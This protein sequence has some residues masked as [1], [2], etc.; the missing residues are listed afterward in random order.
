MNL[1]KIGQFPE[2][3]KQKT[4]SNLPFI[5]KVPTV[6][7]LLHYS[8]SHLSPFPSENQYKSYPKNTRII[9][10]GSYGINI[11]TKLYRINDYLSRTNKEINPFRTTFNFMKMRNENTDLKRK[12][13]ID[14][15]KADTGLTY[16]GFY[17]NKKSGE[18][19]INSARVSNNVLNLSLPKKNINKK[20]LTKS[21]SVGAL[22]EKIDNINIEKIIMNML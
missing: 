2:N 12:D 9:S 21:E 16:T 6:R 22:D 14:K 13:S 19:I 4:S 11:H 20:K 18:S 8:N 7:K 10:Y 3:L 1:N 5:K 15:F 17:K